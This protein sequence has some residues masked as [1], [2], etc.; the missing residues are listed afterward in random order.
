MR[1]IDEIIIHCSATPADMDIGAAEIKHLHTSPQTYPIKWGRYKTHGRGWS[2]IGYHLVIR[3]N[4]EV[5]NGRPLEKRGAHARGHNSHSIGIVVVGEDNN[6]EEVQWNTL[7]YV[8]GQYLESYPDARI[9]G[10]YQVDTKKPYC[11]GFDVPEWVEENFKE[12]L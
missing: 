6:F 9:K 3:R 7:K 10:H 5:E 4:G 12:A 2:D 8:V 11:P 1:S